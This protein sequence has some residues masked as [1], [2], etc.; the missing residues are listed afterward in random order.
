MLEPW[1]GYFVNNISGEGIELLIP[2][3]ESSAAKKGDGRPPLLAE[4]GEW[5]LRFSARS[6]VLGT[7][8][9]IAGMR[10]G[11]RSGWDGFDRFKPPPPPGRRRGLA[12]VPAGDM[13]AEGDLRADIREV[14][15]ELSE[16]RFEVSLPK[17]VETSLSLASGRLPGQMSAL[18]VDDVASAAIPVDGQMEY[19]IVPRPAEESRVLRLGGGPGARAPAA[20]YGPLVPASRFEVGRPYPNPALPGTSVRY[21]IPEGGEVQ[22]RVYGLSGRLVRELAGGPEVAGE[23]IAV[24]DGRD[25]RGREVGTGI[26]FL[27]LAHRGEVKTARVVVFR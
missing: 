18:L 21:A 8:E 15:S 5:E 3:R 13:P 12:I 22:L 19:R 11:A 7:S 17:G 26:Y 2:A 16:W 4:E 6:R 14:S 20:G 9:I 23:H 27:R 10:G 24:W 25:E 1:R